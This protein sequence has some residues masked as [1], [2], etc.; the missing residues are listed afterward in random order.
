MAFSA[1]RLADVEGRD[2]VLSSSPPLSVEQCSGISGQGTRPS[3]LVAAKV[4]VTF[5]KIRL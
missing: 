5:L 1:R 2:F 3:V 4:L